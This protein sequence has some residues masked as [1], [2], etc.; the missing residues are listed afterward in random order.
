MIQIKLEIDHIFEFVTKD[1]V[2]ELNNQIVSSYRKIYNKT[3][4]GADFLGW[5]DLPS[6]TTD[7]L[8]SQIKSHAEE[9][10]AKS[11]IVVV[12]G[13]GGSYLGSRAVIES[14]AH[15]FGGLLNRQ[16]PQI[17]YAGQNISEEYLADLID[18]LDIKHYSLVVISKSGTTTEPAIAFRILKNHLE[19]KYGI[20]EARK[21]IVAIT[22]KSRGALKQLADNEG[23][24]SYVVP[25][26]VGGRYSVLTPVGLLPIALA[27]I[28]IQQLVE[29][30]RKMEAASRA[31]NKMYG[32]PMALYAAARQA[33]YNRGKTI[34]I[35]VNYEPRL[36]YLTEWWKQLYGESEGKELKGIF[37]AG[38]GFT[39]D[40]HSMGQYIQEG[41]RNIFETVISVGNPSKEL[42]VPASENDLDQLNYIAGKRLSEANLMAEFGTTLAHVDGGVPNIRIQIPGIN[43]DIVGQ[44]IYFFEMGC[45]LSGYMLGVNPFD[46]PGVEAYKKNM[47]AL[48]GKEGFEEQTKILQQRLHGKI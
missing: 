37:P 31:V 7:E 23:Y 15:H 25:D 44:L 12:V 24:R 8:I 19:K 5:V 39:T 40:L 3:G 13:I 38:V 6:Q 46:Q 17:V 33:L 16:L 11:E 30:A 29:G 1:Q 4:E 20:I 34:E 9:L 47:F 26:D 10:R 42:R 36:F 35:M 41:L 22:D 28:D 21:R 48:L 32:N 2:Y 43:P 14:M 45:A 27:G 18:L